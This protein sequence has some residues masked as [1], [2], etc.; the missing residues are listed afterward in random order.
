MLLEN[1]SSFAPSQPPSA[2]NSGHPGPDAITRGKQRRR[3]ERAHKHHK[4]ALKGERYGPLGGGTWV[5][6][7]CKRVR[8]DL[9]GWRLVDAVEWMADRRFR[10]WTSGDQSVIDELCVRTMNY[11]DLARR[12][13]V[14]RP[15]WLDGLVRELWGSD[16][17]GFPRADGFIRFIADLLHARR[18][19]AVGLF[20]SQVDAATL[21]DVSDRTFRRWIKHAE[22]AKL[23]RVVQTWREDRVRSSKFR[24]WGKTL[25][26]LGAAIIKVGGAA[27]LEG[28]DLKLPDGR[29][30][31]PVAQHRARALRRDRR[32]EMRTRHDAT[33]QLAKVSARDRV[34]ERAHRR[35]PSFNSL[36]TVSRSARKSVRQWGAGAPSPTENRLIKDA[37]TF[38]DVSGNSPKSQT[39]RV[40]PTGQTLASAP[41]HRFLVPTP[42]SSD[43]VTNS[44]APDFRAE[45]RTC[46]STSPGPG[47][48][49]GYADSAGRDAGDSEKAWTSFSPDVER[50]IAERMRNGF[51]A[52][53]SMFLLFFLASTTVEAAPVAQ[54]KED[55][56]GYARHQQ[57]ISHHCHPITGVQRLCGRTDDK[58]KEHNQEGAIGER[59]AVVSAERV[60]GRPGGRVREGDSEADFSQPIAA[61]HTRDDGSPRDRE[62]AQPGGRCHR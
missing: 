12:M 55:R 42:D 13:V 10:Q 48:Q 27:L 53:L 4:P 47:P 51:G 44:N 31:A 46:P 6:K 19:H 30:M 40:G 14:S 41:P 35:A 54:N 8:T 49:R 28:L 2:P 26:M 16:G 50:M 36:D 45:K 58:H 32:A 22:H 7:G 23:V 1:S 25:Y 29:P 62:S 24:C 38:T 34:V 59:G 37:P 60:E 3:L 43:S 57:S 39:E 21:Y 17:P 9:E 15:C 61:H 11:G 18:S 52:V 5:R 56:N 20:L 33:W